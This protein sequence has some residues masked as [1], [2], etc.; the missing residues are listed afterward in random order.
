MA[1]SEASWYWTEQ[2]VAMSAARV[3]C[4]VEAG[5][6]PRTIAQLM[7]KSGISI[8]E[9]AFVILARLSGNDTQLQAGAYEAV[10]GDKPRRLLERMANGEMTQTR[11]TL[12]EG[13]TYQRIREAR[14]EEPQGKKRT[15]ENKSELQS[16]MRIAY[17]GV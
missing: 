11:L 12:L 13:W 14:R 1:S 9:D 5:S 8:N 4:V 6:R 17:A 10:R 7:K 15:E 3:N 16:L 2:P